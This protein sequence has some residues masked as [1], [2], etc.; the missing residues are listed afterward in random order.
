MQGVQAQR[1]RRHYVLFLD[2]R[3]AFDSVLRNLLL[4]KLKRQGFPTSL[5][6]AVALLLDKTSVVV[7]G[8]TI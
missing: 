1:R 6:K 2:L 3:K 8:V 4:L 5:I 7:D